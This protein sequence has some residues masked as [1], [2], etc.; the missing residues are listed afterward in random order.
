MIASPCINVCAMDAASGLC[1][2]CGRTLDEI[3]RWGGMSDRERREIMLALPQRRKT[4]QVA[5]A[6]IDEAAR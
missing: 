5:Q 4:A 2:G 3:A 1:T 6:D